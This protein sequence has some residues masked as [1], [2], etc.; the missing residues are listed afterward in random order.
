MYITFL[1]KNQKIE[2]EY[3]VNLM[4]AARENGIDTGGTCSGNKT[5]GKCKV[6]ITKGNDKVL[7]TEES[8]S[9][10]E[11]ERNAGFRLACCF[12]VTSDTTVI[13]SKN[14]AENKIKYKTKKQNTNA[15]SFG[16][17]IDLGT[18]TVEAE[19]WDLDNKQRL[20]SQSMLNPQRLYGADVISRITY[21]T[22]SLE[23][24][25]RLTELIRQ[26]CNQLIGLLSEEAGIGKK[27]I[28]SVVIAANTTMSHLFLG[29]SLESLAKVPF[30][31]IS[32]AGEEITASSINILTHPEGSVYV[33][34]GI[35]GHV[36][37]DT[38]G[39]ILAKDMI[40]AKGLELMMDIGTNGE[41]VL[42]K[43]GALVACS[44]AAGPAFEGSSLHHGMGAEP[45]AITKVEIIENQIFLDVIG[46]K[47]NNNS[48]TKPIGICGSGVIDAVSEIYKNG[49]MDGSGRLQGK[50]GENN[51]ILLYED[52]LQSQ[53]V[54]LTQKDIREI[55]L[56]KGAIY[57]GLQLLLREENMSSSD[58]DT[59]YLAGNFGN[60]IN[61]AKGIHIG[62][63]PPIALERIR[64]IGNGALTG[65]V[66]ILL[67]EISK[68]E[69]E[70]ISKK[71]KHIELA[72]REDFQEEFLKAISFPE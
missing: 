11:E 67:G 13:L 56:A 9:V 60:Y 35:G 53:N 49:W 64:Y 42:S 15:T 30:Q 61:I 26:C 31:G 22:I 44:T 69:A 37:S 34:P 40:H 38:L 16:I 10:S 59:L 46:A 14:Q 58:L 65:A 19:L 43:N 32:Y 54:I 68:E 66:K 29:K 6:L 62:L 55:Q 36:G 12:N 21:A 3:G 7:C 4:Q 27:D 41:I 48:T 70:R 57:A 5:C 2:V 63:L 52:K 39:C 51:Y 45:G 33:M 18:T 20:G 23:N 1:P 28:Y 47:N 17:A 24:S 71:V 8:P 25:N 50:A 72:L